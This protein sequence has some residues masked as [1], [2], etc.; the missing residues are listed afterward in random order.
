[1]ESVVSTHEI[2]LEA[3]RNREKGVVLKLAY[4]KAYDRVN[5]YFLEEMMSTRGFGSKWIGWIMKLV[6]CGSIAVR[7]N[8]RNSS[9]FKPGKGLRQGDHLSPLLFNFVADVFTRMLSRAANR[10]YI[11][12]LMT[13]L[14]P[15][16]VISLQYADDTLLFLGNDAQEA[17]HLKWIIVCFK[18]LSRM[19]IN[20]NKS[21]QTSINLEEDVAMRFVSIFCCKLGSFP[22]KYLGCP[23]TMIS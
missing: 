16:G 7:L 15:H 13:A 8:D 11:T 10:G 20:Y 17:C 6:K 22:F 12:G 5:W 14:Y 1:L 9:Y 3:V 21:D 23:F 4:E 18:H 2:I 19:K